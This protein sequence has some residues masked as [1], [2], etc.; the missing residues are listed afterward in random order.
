VIGQFRGKRL[1][2]G[3]LFAGRLFGPQPIESTT[4]SGGRRI[5]VRHVNRRVDV[6]R[7]IEEQNEAIIALMVTLITTGLLD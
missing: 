3:R 5:R 1:F 4:S 6:G 2:A 7:D